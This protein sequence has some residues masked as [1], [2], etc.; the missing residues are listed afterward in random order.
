VKKIELTILSLRK[1]INSHEILI[2]IFIFK[3]YINILNANGV[4]TCTDYINTVN[5]TFLIEILKLNEDIEELLIIKSILQQTFA[6][7]DQIYK[8]NQILLNTNE[9]QNSSSTL[10]VNKFSG[11]IFFLMIHFINTRVC[12]YGIDNNNTK[13]NR[14]KHVAIND[15]SILNVEI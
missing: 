15:F 7:N 3:A 2:H 8:S 6:Q 11:I 14:N 9:L 12:L 1:N 13:K 10:I 5:E 4:R